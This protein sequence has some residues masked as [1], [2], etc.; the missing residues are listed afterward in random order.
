[1]ATGPL[2]PIARQTKRAVEVDFVSA[3]HDLV[4]Q[5][6]IAVLRLVRNRWGKLQKVKQLAR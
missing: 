2:H 6:L 5:C 3:D 1:M 4:R